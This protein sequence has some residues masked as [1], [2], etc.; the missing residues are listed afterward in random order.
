MHDEYLTGVR[1]IIVFSSWP[2]ATT[3]DNQIAWRLLLHQSSILF[4]V[5]LIF[6]SP[7]FAVFSRSAIGKNKNN[8]LTETCSIRKCDRLS[9]AGWFGGG[10]EEVDVELSW[11]CFTLDQLRP[12]KQDK[13][14]ARVWYTAGKCR[15]QDRKYRKMDG[16]TMPMQ[17]VPCGFNRSYRQSTQSSSLLK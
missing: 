1:F 6:C 16:R 13:N 2:Y 3:I 12:N 17:L 8:K 15:G 14:E 5:N 10:G 4:K 11:R 7:F 9:T